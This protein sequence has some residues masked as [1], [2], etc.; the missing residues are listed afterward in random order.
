MFSCCDIDL[1]PVS[2]G[3]SYIEQFIECV[4]GYVRASVRVCVCV[5]ANCVCVCFQVSSYR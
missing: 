1:L 3:T 2:T 5:C 4:R